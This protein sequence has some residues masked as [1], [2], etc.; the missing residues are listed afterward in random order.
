MSGLY[1]QDTPKYPLIADLTSDFV[2]LR[3]QDAKPE[4]E[5][6]YEAK[7]LDK[8]VA[9]ARAWQRGKEPDEFPLG[10]KRRQASGARRVCLFHQW[11]QGGAPAAAEAMISILAT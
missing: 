5:T 7:V 4:I 6:G 3:L 1:W 2:Y 10:T 11:R 9:L 8:W